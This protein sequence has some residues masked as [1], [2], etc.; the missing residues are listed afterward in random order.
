[1]SLKHVLGRS[2]CGIKRGIPALFLERIPPI[3]RDGLPGDQ[4]LAYY[5]ERA[6]GGAAIIS[7]T[8]CFQLLQQSCPLGS[9]DF[10]GVVDRVRSAMEIACKEISYRIEN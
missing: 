1:M 10:C 3:W 7:T 4:H 8:R 9:T 2:S 5:L 6:I